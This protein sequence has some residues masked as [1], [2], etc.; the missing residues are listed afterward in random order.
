MAENDIW[1][2]QRAVIEHLVAE[3][4]KL[5]CIHEYLFEVYGEATVHVNTDE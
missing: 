5:T 1:L 3:D 2:K 4:K